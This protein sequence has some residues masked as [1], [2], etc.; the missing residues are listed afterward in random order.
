MAK[1]F[2]LARMTTATTGTGTITL[3][4]AVSGYLSFALAGVS[5]G[6]ILDYAIKDGNNSEIGTGTYT[7]A[8]LTLTRNVTNSTNSNAAINLSGAAEVFITPRADT[9]ITSIKVQ[10]FTSSGTY[11]PSTG[12]VFC[13]IE[14]LGGGGG[15]GGANNDSGS[16]SQAYGGGGGGAGGY[17][18]KYAIAADVGASKGVTIGANGI[19]GFASNVGTAG[20]DT[21]VG[22]PAICVGKGGSGGSYGSLSSY[23]Y[24]G[25]GGVAGTGDVTPAGASGISGTYSQTTTFSGASGTGGSSPFG[26]GGRGIFV[27]GNVQTGLNATGYGSG[28]SGCS[29]HGVTNG[30]SG[31]AGTPGLVIITEFCNGKG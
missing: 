8:G 15:G 16:A 24:G 2:N 3:G 21:S 6:D 25:S 14:C 9:L 22:S 1:L 10:K 29:T 11:T 12:M 7:S 26:G 31:G 18:R 30:G 5:N 19:G 17:S 13:I 23:P 28:G 20:G 27:N 4:A